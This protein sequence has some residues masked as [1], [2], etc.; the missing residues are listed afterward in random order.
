MKLQAK[1]LLTL[2]IAVA[3]T[4]YFIWST[5]QDHERSMAAQHWVNHTHQIINAV[6]DAYTLLAETE[7]AVRGHAITRDTVF[8]SGLNEKVDTIHSLSNRL[9]Q[10]VQDS[11]EQSERGKRLQSTIGRKLRLQEE[12]LSAENKSAIEGLNIIYSLKVKMLMDSVRT[13]WSEIKVAESCLLHE[14]ITSNETVSSSV[15]KTGLVAGIISLIFTVGI[16]LLWNRDML[17]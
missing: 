6:D 7:S 3:G 10:L 9:L 8:L 4:G 16:L 11:P 5:Y 15:L 2:I 17:L 12:I 13:V 1:I 14:R